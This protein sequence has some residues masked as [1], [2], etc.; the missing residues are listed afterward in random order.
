MPPPT[1]VYNSQVTSRSKYQGAGQ[2]FR[3]KRTRGTN[4]NH[5]STRTVC[6]ALDTQP[7]QL[8]KP[9]VNHAFV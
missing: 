2:L 4:A 1:Y 6:A 9:R 7:L 8:G 5:T 3:L